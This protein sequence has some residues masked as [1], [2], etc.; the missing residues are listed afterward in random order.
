MAIVL[1]HSIH[2]KLVSE[3]DDIILSVVQ[4]S[5]D[6]PCPGRAGFTPSARAKIRALISQEVI[7]HKLVAFWG[8]VLILSGNSHI[9]YLLCHIEEKK[10][11]F[12][13]AAK[14]K[15]HVRIS[16]RRYNESLSTHNDGLRSTLKWLRSRILFIIG[17]WAHGSK[18]IAAMQRL[19]LKANCESESVATTAQC[20][21]T[22]FVLALLAS[23]CLVTFLIKFSYLF[24][25]FFLWKD[26][27]FRF[28]AFVVLFALWKFFILQFNIYVEVNSMCLIAC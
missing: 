9:S 3:F 8:L 10:I 15:L 28:F 18:S 23:A 1:P 4:D 27:L 6:P 26:F 25:L 7:P 5:S 20:I 16:I 24:A 22:L 12:P 17:E 19:W 14:L 11:C 2:I 13:T 21:W